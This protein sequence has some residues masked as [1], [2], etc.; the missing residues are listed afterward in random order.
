VRTLSDG[1]GQA[2]GGGRA[3]M[4]NWGQSV[5]SLVGKVESCCWM[6]L[7]VWSPSVV[8]G[9]PYFLSLVIIRLDLERKRKEDE[10]RMDHLT[11]TRFPV[12]LQPTAS[13]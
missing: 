6:S 3:G 1:L 9:L 8:G 5:R 7:L 11:K 4:S 10:K 2:G 12:P 13:K